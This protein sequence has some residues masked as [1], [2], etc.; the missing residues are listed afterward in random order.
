MPRRVIVA[1][2][3]LRQLVVSGYRVIYRVDHDTGE[4]STAG[5]VRILA[6]FGPGESSL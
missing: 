1:P 6:L 3:T 2:A 4:G 5:D